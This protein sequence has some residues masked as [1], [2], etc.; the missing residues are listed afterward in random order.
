M[1]G[2]AEEV[3]RWSG[4]GGGEREE[5]GFWPESEA[6]RNSPCRDGEGRGRTR[7]GGEEVDL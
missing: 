2:R 3:S 6:G 1:E 5:S 4:L 7:L